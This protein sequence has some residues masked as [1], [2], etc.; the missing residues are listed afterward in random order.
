M[1]FWGA[2][3]GF[4]AYV[5]FAYFVI[6]GSRADGWMFLYAMLGLSIV[7]GLVLLYKHNFEV[8]RWHDSDYSPYASDD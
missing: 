3:F 2:W 8:R 7:P 5:L 4:L 1:N 6:G